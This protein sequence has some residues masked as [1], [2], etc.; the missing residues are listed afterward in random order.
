MARPWQQRGDLQARCDALLGP[1]S[2]PERRYADSTSVRDTETCEAS[3]AT[4]KP[5]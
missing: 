5:V 4:P 3:N 2:D 1:R